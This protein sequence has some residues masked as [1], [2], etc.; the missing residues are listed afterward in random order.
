V[1][2]PPR[3]TIFTDGSCLG[4]PGPGGWAALLV[5]GAHEKELVG[6]AAHTTNNKMELLAVVEGLRALKKPCAIE[7]V[8]DST[9]VV[10]GMT[11]WIQGWIKRGWKNSKKQPVE[12]QD[13][14]RA[15]LEASAPHEVTW[16]WV[17]GHA[18][19]KE[20]ERV[21]VLARTFAEQVQ[22]GRVP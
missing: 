6:G 12:N 16:R 22:A 18:G 1:A 15:L 9:Y 14:W 21:D 3:V 7:V 19:H 8:T 4:N 20:N 13:L 2:A 10:K 5:S 17:R 11:E